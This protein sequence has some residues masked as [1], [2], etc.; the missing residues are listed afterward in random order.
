MKKS[1][2]LGMILSAGLFS[3]A[4]AEDYPT[5]DIDLVVPFAPG[6]AVDVTSRLIAEAANRHVDGAKI[7]V[8]N[9]DGGGGIVGQSFVASA[10]ADGYTVL[11]MTSSVVTNP[12]LKG[13]P[14]KVSDFTPVAAYNIDPEVIVVPAKS[15][16]K[17]IAD[18]VA[19]A[20]EKPLNAVVAGIGTSHHMAGLG[21]ESSAGMKFNYIPAK[22][23]GEQLQAIAG[24]HADLSFWAMGEAM[25]HAKSGT[26]RILAIA[27]DARDPNF[28]DVPTFEEAGLG[29]S[30]WATFRGWAVPAGTPDNVVAYLSDL[31]QKVANDPDYQQK[32]TDGGYEPIYRNAADFTKIMNAYASQA[33][34]IIEEH[35][36][37]K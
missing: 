23:F 28:P 21:L 29:M 34:A 12:Q 32:M 3:A 24:Q 33:S 7:V 14:Y 22:G 15:P 13:A 27:S 30:I 11:A 26:V 10:D 4:F 18:L 5:R 20:K 31:M 37:G 17:S 9:R 2:A 1:I 36:L 25:S 19:A 16:F 8:S 35:K 6:G